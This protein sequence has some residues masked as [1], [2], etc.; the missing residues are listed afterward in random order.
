MP[1]LEF[2]DERGN[3][4]A[5]DAERVE[6]ISTHYGPWATDYDELND[7]ERQDLYPSGVVSLISTETSTYFSSEE[8]RTLIRRLE[9]LRNR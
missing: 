1:M 2:D 4:A 8:A 5:V 6:G 7:A 3:L 9:G